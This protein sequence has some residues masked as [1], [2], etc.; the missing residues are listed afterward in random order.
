M[1]YQRSRVSETPASIHVPFNGLLE[2]IFRN[3]HN[4][5]ASMITYCDLALYSSAIHSKFICKRAPW[6]M[7]LYCK[8][9]FDP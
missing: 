3:V 6:E 1:G 8:D 4:V 2:F 9:F 5:C 7:E